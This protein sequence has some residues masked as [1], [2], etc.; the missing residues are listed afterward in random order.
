MGRQTI[1]PKKGKPARGSKWDQLRRYL[2]ESSDRK[3]VMMTDHGKEKSFLA[4]RLRKGAK[5]KGL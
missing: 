4:E 3:M 2:S 1:M 5:G